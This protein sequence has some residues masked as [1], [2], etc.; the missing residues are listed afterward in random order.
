[1]AVL[2]NRYQQRA[3][4]DAVFD[5]ESALLE[6]YGHEVIRL[7]EEVPADAGVRDMIGIAAGLPWS[8]KQYKRVRGILERERP[9]V[10]HAHNMFPLFTPSVLYAANAAGVPTVQTLHNY[11]LLCPGA[12]FHREGRI[13]EDCRGKASL[14]PAALHGCYR[15]SR[16]ESVAIAATISIHRRMRSWRDQVAVFVALTEF[17]KDVYE[18][19]GF[20]SDKMVV[21]PNFVEPDPGPGEGIRD[22]AVYVGR[23]S[24]EKGVGTLIEAWKRMEGIPLKIAGDGPLSDLVENELSRGLSAVEYLGRRT[25]SDVI[26]LVRGARFLVFPSEWYEG[27]PVTIAEAFAAGTPVIAARLGGM[28]EI[29]SDNRTGLHFEA[30]DAADLVAKASE[31][32]RRPEDAEIMGQNARREYESRFS[33]PK[34]YEMLVDIYRAAIARG[35]AG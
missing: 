31:L 21:K 33:A 12:T 23:L 11:R 8:R 32:W 29:V 10:L 24:P 28:A 15:S 2:H 16:I 22:Y 7:T 20:P 3:G 17:M 14:Y 4:E 5:A 26:N 25:R 9:D 6:R 30:G 35:V 19:E 34:N 13:C 27:F 1:M 18:Q